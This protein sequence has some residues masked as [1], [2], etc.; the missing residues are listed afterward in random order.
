MQEVILYG[1]GRRCNRIVSLLQQGNVCIKCI[2]DTNSEKWGTSLLGIEVSSPDVIGEFRE[3][4][5]CITMA[6]LE[7][8]AVV[9]EKI[10]TEYQY[11]L[12]NEISYYE[13]MMLAYQ[14]MDT[15]R[16]KWN[17]AKKNCKSSIVF[18]CHS[19]LGLGGIEEW[20]KGICTELINRKWDNIRILS[21]G[22]NYALSQSIRPIVDAVEIDFNQ[23]FER[24]N[25][26]RILE[27]LGGCMPVIV[28][29]SKPGVVL[30]AACVLKKMYPSAV[31]IVSVIHGG[32]ESIYKQY[33]SYRGGIDVY[34]GVSVDIKEALVLRGIEKE[35]VYSITCPVRCEQTLERTYTDSLAE[36]LKIGYA[37]R[38]EVEQK[39]MDLFM[40]LI[41]LL[42]RKRVN[43]LF[44][45]AGTGTH[46]EVMERMI[47]EK[48]LQNKVI[49]LGV[50]KREDISCFWKQQDICVNVAD[51][52]GRS[53]TQLEAMANGAIPV[54]TKTSGTKEDIS[55]GANGYL[56][57][58]GDCG[59][60]ADVI[61]YLSENR[62][63]LREMGHLAHET[64]YPKCQKE[65]HTRFWEEVLRKQEWML[66]GEL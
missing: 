42:D 13:L 35:K 7:L 44:R 45:I 46:K 32:H 59:R 2:V 27:Y 9:R 40:Q 3:F 16:D 4:P 26:L 12:R 43:F 17:K 8:Q 53:I 6:D 20:T 5:L 54:V 65:V 25:I 10:S 30:F 50:I 51:F 22:G 47:E 23:Y 11:D 64:I 33:D 29:T 58:P 60:M 39:R 41:E 56:V 63:R 49:F 38:L 24:E 14:S 1:S 34:V 61:E 31:K 66:L 19:G 57:A 36:P 52:E 55:D 15:V 62:E 48:Q 18:D 21:D 37:G 28:V